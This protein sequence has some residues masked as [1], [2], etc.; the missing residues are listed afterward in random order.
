MKRLINNISD[1]T[2]M[3]STINFLKNILIN[4]NY[5]LSSESFQNIYHSLLYASTN[6]IK[7]NLT[8]EE[9]IDI[10]LLISFIN[11]KNENSYSNIVNSFANM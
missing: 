8:N 9:M 2:N 1:G 11:S 10:N 6:K 3:N 7:F 4:L 5:N